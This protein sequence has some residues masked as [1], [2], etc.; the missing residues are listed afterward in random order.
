MS[1]DEVVDV[2]V[3]LQ[4]LLG[5]EDEGLVLFAHVARGTLLLVLEAAMLGPFEAEVYAPTGVYACKHPLQYGVV[6]HAAQEAE[7]TV[8]ISQAI[9]MGKVEHLTSYLNRKGFVVHD[10]AAL[11]DQIVLAPDV[12]VAD[13]EVHLHS[14]VGELAHL[15]EKSCVALGHHVAVLKPEV[16]HVPQHV[17]C[18]G[19]V[20][21]GVKEVYQPPLAGTHR[22]E[23]A[24]AQVCIG[25]EVNHDY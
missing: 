15:T 21:Y 11:L 12:V 9:A 20:L 16:K 2:M 7:L 18:R 13:E 6:E 25:D 10:Y 1:V 5:V 17:Y 14:S 24:A 8:G 22:G 3:C 19:L 4:I 23:C